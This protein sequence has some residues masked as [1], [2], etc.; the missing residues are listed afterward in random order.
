MIAG[1]TALATALGLLLPAV[2]PADSAAAGAAPTTAAAADPRPNI[3]LVVVDDFSMDL[4]STMR[5]AK[6]M[7]R[8]G[9]SYR[10]SY[11][12][13]SRC[14]PSRASLLTGQYP[15]QTGVLGNVDAPSPE[16]PTGGYAAFEAHGN[17]ERSV[18]VQLQGAGYT[19][20]FVGKYLN[21]YVGRTLPPGWSWW[22]AIIGDAY[23][24]WGFRSTIVRDGALQ[25]RQHPAPPA[26]ASEARKDRAYAGRVTRDM[27]VRFIQ[28][29]RD[30]PAPYF[31]EVAPYASHSRVTTGG[32]YP[33]DPLFPPAFRDRRGDTCGERPCGRLD[34]RDLPGFADPQYDNVPRYA[35]GEPAPQWRKAANPPATRLTRDLRNRARMAQSINRLLA[36]VLDNVDRNTY[37]MLTSDNGFHLGQHRLGRGKG[38]PF[39][40]DV[41]VPLLV[42]GPGVTPG[43][44]GEVVSNIDLA[45]TFEELAGLTPAPYRSGWSLVPTFDNPSLNR[46]DTTFFVHADLPKEGSADDPDAPFDSSLKR[47]PSYTAVRTRGA[48]LVRFDLDPTRDGVDHAWEYYDYSRVKWEKTNTYGRPAH[49]AE[50]ERLASKIERFDD[51][52]AAVRNDAVPA[53]C[54]SLTQ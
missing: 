6:V 36:R 19:T 31:L 12:V 33:G 4:L 45:P 10:H 49:A 41:R 28:S 26:S 5:Q 25:V 47:I 2:G 17:Y 54:R 9:A 13:D 53:E 21:G 48:L 37:V 39:T 30:D 27:A 35:N 51:C 18:N 42:V 1:A 43:V 11:V 7:R 29:H 32:A 40:S 22:R 16:G 24:G 15:H 8:N 44:R 52:S 38:T 34:A 46:R 23:D 20:G 14:C 50:I 3:V